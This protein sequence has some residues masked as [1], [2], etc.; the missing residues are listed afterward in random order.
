MSAA[1]E[2]AYAQLGQIIDLSDVS[3]PKHKRLV[4][5][6]SDNEWTLHLG[7][8]QHKE[9]YKISFDVVIDSGL[10]L[11]D[12]VDLLK[13]VK[14]LILLSIVDT[15]AAKSPFGNTDSIRKYLDFILYLV[16]YLR[17]IGVR[18]PINA[19]TGDLELFAKSLVNTVGK[20]LQYIRRFNEFSDKKG[21]DLSEYCDKKSG[22]NRGTSFDLSRMLFD[23]GI[24][25]TSWANFRELA[26][27]SDSLRAKYESNY[28]ID[29]TL[30]GNKRSIEDVGKKG[31]VIKNV[32]FL[33]RILKTT[34]HFPSLIPM[35]PAMTLPSE[36]ILKKVIQNKAKADGKTKD[37]PFLV[38]R[39]TLERSIRYIIHFSQLTKLKDKALE[40]F[41]GY[42][43]ANPSRP[44]TEIAK[45]FFLENPII[46]EGDSELGFPTIRITNFDR[47]SPVKSTTEEKAQW[48]E[49]A[50][51]NANGDSLKKLATEKGVAKST[52]ALWIRKH[53]DPFREQEFNYGLST[54]LHN[55]MMVAI[56]MVLCFLTARRSMEV[57]NLEAGCISTTESGHWI[58]MYVAK[59][60][61][62]HDDF[63]ATNLIKVCVEI[64]EKLSLTARNETG[65]DKLF[66]YASF[67]DPSNVSQYEFKSCRAAFLEFIGITEDHSW[68]WSEHQFRRFFAG[69]FVNHF[70]GSVDALKYHLRHTDIAMT[71]EYLN[72][73]MTGATLDTLQAEAM[74]EVLDQQAQANGGFDD[75]TELGKRLNECTECLSNAVGITEKRAHNKRAFERL[76]QEDDI[77]FEMIEEGLCVGNTKKYRHR[78][79]CIVDDGGFAQTANAD[80]SFC[81]GCENKIKLDNWEYKN[82]G[83]EC[84]MNPEDSDILNAVVESNNDWH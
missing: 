19:T 61:Q 65:N 25:L 17:V 58:K 10:S 11:V 30:S 50:I 41:E 75:E 37:V 56:E 35:F 27:T 3:S 60:Y 81:A 78:S 12:E 7:E 77:V 57:N 16:R 45:K 4:S 72:K 62:V 66:Q 67:I 22:N 51:R 80:C 1:I 59:T 76:V 36:K 5:E 54:F 13:S 71:F 69:T 84:L 74:I 33:N 49:V 28:R 46:L 43:A 29:K 52:I 70:G 8:E 14:W 32:S 79:K 68:D 83:N 9:D 40:G 44:R 34:T 48:A 2:K 6:F 20:N 38:M 31:S 21:G 63:P 55:H 23:I 64:L 73:I 82:V 24:P 47:T 26:E 39:D 53:N 18:R 15:K 42:M